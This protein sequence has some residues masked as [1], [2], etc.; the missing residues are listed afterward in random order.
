MD[1]QA[2]LCFGLDLDEQQG[3]GFCYGYSV[4]QAEYTRNLLFDSGA[5]MEEL[6]DRMLDR[7]R[8]RLDIPAIRTLLASRP[9]RIA[10]ARPA[11]RRKTS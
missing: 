9:G 8:S 2:C 11:R 10:T 7:T 1:L 3:S 6:F 5:Q 4:Y